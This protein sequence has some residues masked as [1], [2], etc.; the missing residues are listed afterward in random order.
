[1]QETMYCFEIKDESS[2]YNWFA[3]FDTPDHL[4]MTLFEYEKVDLTVE[5]EYGR[6]DDPYRILL[7]RIPGNQ[8]QSFLKVVELLPDIMEYTGRKD[9][10][11]FCRSML[12]AADRFMERNGAGESIPLQ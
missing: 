6:E 3:Y 2:L 7:V 11:A 8:R 4:A 12:M 9:Y 10:D 1:M 5:G